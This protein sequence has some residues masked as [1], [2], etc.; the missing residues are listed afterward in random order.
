[1]YCNH[2]V[3]FH[4][5]SSRHEM[6]IQFFA[7]ATGFKEHFDHNV[8][9]KKAVAEL[10]DNLPLHIMVSR[11]DYLQNVVLIRG[12][13]IASS[14][15]SRK[16]ILLLIATTWHRDRNNRLIKQYFEFFSDFLGHSSLFFQK[17]MKILMEYFDFPMAVN[18]VYIQT[19]GSVQQFQKRHNILWGR[20]FYSTF[21]YH[22]RWCIDPPYHGKGDCDS[23]GGVIKRA[24]RKHALRPGCN[25]DTTRQLVAFTNERLH[26]VT[27]GHAFVVKVF[28]TDVEKMASLC[29]GIKSHFDYIFDQPRPRYRWR[30]FPCHCHQCRVGL[31]SDCI[32]SDL[33]GPLVVKPVF[34][35]GTRGPKATTLAATE[36]QLARIRHVGSNPR[37]R[38]NFVVHKILSKRTSENVVEYKVSWVGYAAKYNS[39]LPDGHVN[40]S[41]QVLADFAALN[42]P[43]DNS[44]SSSGKLYLF[45]SW[46]IVHSSFKSFFQILLHL[47]LLPIVTPMK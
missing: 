46:L 45:I 22:L 26:S 24:V 33:S 13:E 3:E 30:K 23:R 2:P 11:W 6:L 35:N 36:Q 21:R 40:L 37:G 34:Q 43:D 12:S 1:M 28:A 20:R 29:P 47:H 39:W 10:L 32:Q 16:Q 19:D 17:C 5:T 8:M 18:T 41:R 42:F 7:Q 9:H 14:Y 4:V 27:P 38:V 31:Y 15:F 25:I 44:S